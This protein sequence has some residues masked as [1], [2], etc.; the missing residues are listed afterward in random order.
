MASN[1]RDRGYSQSREYKTN[2]STKRN[3]LMT[4]ETAGEKINALQ[5]EYKP[6]V[7]K[8]EQ[9]LNKL[10]NIY[11]NRAFANENAPLIQNLD[12]TFQN[13]ERQRGVNIMKRG[14]TDLSGRQ[15]FAYRYDRPDSTIYSAGIDNGNPDRGTLDVSASLP[16]GTIGGGFEGETNYAS[17]E[18]GNTNPYIGA[19]YWGNG[20]QPYEMQ[21]GV[22][23]SDVTGGAELYADLNAPFI[24]S[25]TNR[26]ITTPIGDIQIGSTPATAD[27]NGYAYAN[28][29]PNERANYYIQALANLLGR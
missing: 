8:G 26:T 16:I 15:G 19:Y 12:N 6:V 11:N 2:Q 20:D 22:G 24:R 28:F 1:L 5:T 14:A 23:T 9:A 10:I 13:G 21:A 27:M 25:D 17:Y 7:S 29:A 3:A 4:N 18:P